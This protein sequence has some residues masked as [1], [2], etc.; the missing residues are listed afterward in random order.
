MSGRKKAPKKTAA[1]TLTEKEITVLR[2]KYQRHAQ[3][4]QAIKRRSAELVE[5]KQQLEDSKDAIE[6]KT[7]RVKRRLQIDESTTP[8]FNLDTGE[9]LIDGD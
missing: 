4:Q 3:L 2:E 9:V 8:K 7:L 1:K 6:L 5:L